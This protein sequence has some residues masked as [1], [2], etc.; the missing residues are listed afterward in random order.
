M[1]IK[2]PDQEGFL[3]YEDQERLNQI[4][5]MITSDIDQ[6]L[7]ARQAMDRGTIHKWSEDDPLVKEVME[8][9]DMGAIKVV[10]SAAI[11]A[12]A[13]RW[14]NMEN[15]VQRKA[16]MLAVLA[17]EGHALQYSAEHS[18]IVKGTIPPFMITLWGRR[19]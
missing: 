19:F 10:G 2:L 15:D 1:A 8:K 7:R 6:T 17:A 9:G 11:A 13:S 3:D 16:E 5:Q 4:A 14:K 12:L 18:L